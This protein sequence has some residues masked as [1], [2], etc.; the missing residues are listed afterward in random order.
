[1]KREFRIGEMLI[2]IKTQYKF[3]CCATTEFG[4]YDQCA[5]FY[6]NE[7][8]KKDVRILILGH[9]RHGKDSVADILCERFSLRCTASSKAALPIFM[10]DVLNDKYDKNYK[11]YEEAFNDR[12]NCRDIWYDEIAE[13]NYDDK[14]RLAKEIMKEN[15]IYVGL[16]SSEEVEQCIKEGVFDLIFGVYDYR[17]PHEPINSNTADV[18]KYSKFVIT[19][20]GTLDELKTKVLD[21]FHDV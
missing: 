7:D 8:I 15:D 21:C 2:D 12:V 1:M 10:F 6:K 19:T 16:R 13:Y 17:K 18:F 20:N 14:T 3:K 11:N 4:V 5:T 9:A